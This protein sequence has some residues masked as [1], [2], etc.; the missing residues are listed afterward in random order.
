MFFYKNWQVLNLWKYF[1]VFS[2]LDTRGTL[3]VQFIWVFVRSIAPIRPRFTLRSSNMFLKLKWS[4]WEEDRCPFGALLAERE[5]KIFI[6]FVLMKINETTWRGSRGNFIPVRNP[7]QVLCFYHFV[8]RCRISSG[9][10]RTAFFRIIQNVWIMERPCR[11]M[12]LILRVSKP[13]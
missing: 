7:S 6:K 3:G 12:I 4:L 2:L 5:E 11:L 13:I 1:I 10:R 9:S 8:D